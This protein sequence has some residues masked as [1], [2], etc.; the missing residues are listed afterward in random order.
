[1]TT[2][3]T[4]AALPAIHD[5]RSRSFEWIALDDDPQGA[6]HFNPHPTIRHLQHPNLVS[7]RR[8]TMQSRCRIDDPAAQA[9]FGRL[10]SGPAQV[11]HQQRSA[12]HRS[13]IATQLGGITRQ[14]RDRC[15]QRS[16][17]GGTGMYLDAGAIT[18][19]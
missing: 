9:L 5:W 7:R 2:I 10:C 4:I 13:L 19:K 15:A 6:M 18:R 3:E 12:Q 11:T 1:M 16:A 17:V 8:S 14:R